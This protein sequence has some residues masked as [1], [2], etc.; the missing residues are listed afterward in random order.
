MGRKDKFI[1]LAIA[2]G[3]TKEEAEILYDLLVESESVTMNK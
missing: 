3:Y 1:A 2:K